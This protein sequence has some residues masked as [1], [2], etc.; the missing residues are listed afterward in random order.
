MGF[1]CCERALGCRA[2]L[3][4]LITLIAFV[5]SNFG[6]KWCS[7]VYRVVE[8]DSS[9]IN[10][11]LNSYFF[12]SRDIGLWSYEGIDDSDYDDDLSYG[13]EHLGKCYLYPDDLE[14]DDYFEFARI[15]SCLTA[16]LGGGTAIV[17]IAST[18]CPFGKCVHLILSFVLIATAIMEGLTQ[19]IYF[20][21]FCGGDNDDSEDFVK[22][23]CNASWGSSLSIATTFV[24]LMGACAI[25]SATSA[26]NAQ[27]TREKR[28]YEEP[29]VVSTGTSL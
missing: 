20:S 28:E 21:S 24:W 14:F 19:L 4:L 22:V 23:S 1:C 18:F 5:T 3:P 7:F 8:I 17:L 9:K 6:S 13:H 29:L 26:R 12:V 25:S 11:D 10:K 2:I 27:N 16:I 15:M